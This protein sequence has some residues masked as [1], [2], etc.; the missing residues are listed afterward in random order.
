MIDEISVIDRDKSPLSDADRDPIRTSGALRFSPH[1]SVVALAADVAYAADRL[2]SSDPS[3]SEHTTA[4]LLNY[5]AATCQQAQAVVRF[6][7]QQRS[8]G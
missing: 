2:L 6:L 5:V 8:K 4:E 3:D 7:P 1:I